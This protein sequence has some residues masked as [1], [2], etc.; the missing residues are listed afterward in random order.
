MLWI[1]GSISGFYPYVFYKGQTRLSEFWKWYVNHGWDIFFYLAIPSIVFVL[2]QNTRIRNEAKIAIAYTPNVLMFYVNE[3]MWVYNVNT[4]DSIDKGD[5]LWFL[6]ANMLFLIFVLL[7][8]K[9]PPKKKL[10]D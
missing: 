1:W 2:L 4:T 6:T 7:D 10:K 8:L 3:I 5:T 9:C